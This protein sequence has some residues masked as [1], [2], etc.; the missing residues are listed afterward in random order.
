MPSKLEGYFKRRQKE[1]QDRLYRERVRK[2]RNTG[3]VDSR[4]PKSLQ[5]KKYAENLKRRDKERRQFK[6]KMENLKLLDTI[7]K[8]TMRTSP[9]K[10]K[11]SSRYRTTRTTRCV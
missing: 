8:V 6:I 1:V 3:A 11:R 10:P 2:A 7:R 4:P 5:N 9:P